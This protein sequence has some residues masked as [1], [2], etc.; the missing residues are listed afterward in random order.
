MRIRRFTAP[1]MAEALRLV[2]AAL[3]ADAVLLE[4]HTGADGVS[5]SAAVDD[6]PGVLPGLTPGGGDAELLGEVRALMALVRELALPAGDD[7]EARALLCRIVGQGVERELAAALVAAA[8]RRA[9]NGE[10][11]A[12]A[13][14]RALPEPPAIDERVQ[15]VFGPPGEGKTTTLVQLAARA[16]C[17][18]RRVCL[19]GADA[20]RLG[21]AAELSAYGRVLDVP[22]VRAATP[23]AVAA[24]VAAAD[25]DV[26]LVDT[27]GAAP[28][29]KDE[30]AELAALAARRAERLPASGRESATNAAAAVE[31]RLGRVRAAQP[32]GRRSDQMRR[33]LRRSLGRGAVAGRG[34]DRAAGARTA[35]GGRP[36]ARDPGAPGT[37]PAHG[38][39]GGG[40]LTAWTR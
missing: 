6:D 24:A 13:L 38:C 18:G 21:A 23:D 26:V 36:A 1:T 15:V 32:G 2:K 20:V 12:D 28:G 34:A 5:V 10:P 14:V 16:R 17:E 29:Q 35:H 9:A 19:V 27:P 37:V 33:G 4:T 3:G 40:R 11:L 25:A 39:R 7:D 8:R 22:V 31:K 30:L